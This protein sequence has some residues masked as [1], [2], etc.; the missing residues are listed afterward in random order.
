MTLSQEL[1]QMVV[2]LNGTPAVVRSDLDKLLNKAAD[3]I[4]CLEFEIN[5]VTAYAPAMA[6]N[7]TF[8]N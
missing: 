1:R 8:N 2:L 3:K 7:A 4:D 6:C 5:F